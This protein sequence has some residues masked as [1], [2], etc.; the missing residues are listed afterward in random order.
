MIYP[1]FVRGDML[2]CRKSFRI[3]IRDQNCM[4][5]LLFD[6][7]Y[8]GKEIELESLGYEAYSVKKLRKK[9]ALRY[10]YSIIKFAEEEDMI[11]IT[12]DTENKGGCDENNIP[13]IQFGQNPSCSEILDQV[14]KF[15]PK[16]KIL[17]KRRRII[18]I[19]LSVVSVSIWLLIAPKIFGDFFSLPE[20]SRLFTYAV[21]TAAIGAFLLYGKKLVKPKSKELIFSFELFELLML[22][23][24]P[25]FAAF[26]I[27]STE[28]R[29]QPLYIPV[30][31][32][33]VLFLWFSVAI[34]QNTRI[35]KNH[36][37]KSLFAIVQLYGS[38]T[39]FGI[40]LILIL[41]YIK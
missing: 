14:K 27:L 3:M 41:I 10:D 25:M 16:P 9:R 2:Y 24:S 38:M 32:M 31:F 21:I 29:T 20:D 15:E 39:A 34:Y 8:D 30:I 11:L 12:E 6:E 35:F 18:K 33:G 40:S 1:R 17:S 7:M 19:V 5:P 22:M 36:G 23:I 26:S 37:K 13:C 4:R 28:F